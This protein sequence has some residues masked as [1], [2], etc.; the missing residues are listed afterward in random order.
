MSKGTIGDGSRL[1]FIKGASEVRGSLRLPA[2]MRDWYVAQFVNPLESDLA[3]S[4][5]I[6]E[7]RSRKASQVNF[8]WHESVMV[9]SGEVMVQDSAS[10][11][12]YGGAEGDL[13]YLGPGL[14]ARIGGEFRAYYVAT[15]PVFRWLESADG[16]IQA[17]DLMDM[18]KDVQHPGTPASEVNQVLMAEGEG[19]TNKT[20]QVKIKLLKGA[21]TASTVPVDDRTEMPRDSWRQVDLINPADSNLRL[22]AGIAEH[23]TPSM[24]ERGTYFWYHQLVMVLDGEMVI[25]DLDTGGIYRAGRGDF[26]YWAPGHSHKN[27]GRFRAFFVKTPI[28]L[29]WVV[30]PQG[31]K[32]IDTRRLQ[33]ETEYPGSPPESTSKAPLP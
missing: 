6:V 16:S 19:L 2:P 29:R 30:T 12:V 21:M 20:D 10:G 13:F 9:L 25:E 8:R 33:G 3:L 1:K 31:K 22:V 27:G 4:A 18:G 11:E 26:Y 15:P 32:V 14:E 5:G 7:H 28:P 24:P 23:P 17:V